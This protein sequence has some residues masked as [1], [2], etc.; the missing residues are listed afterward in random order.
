VSVAKASFD[1]RLEMLKRVTERESVDFVVSTA[2]QGGWRIQRFWNSQRSPSGWP[3][4]TLL[5]EGSDGNEM[6]CIECKTM[7]GRTRPGQP[8]CLDLIDGVVTV[9]AYLLRPSDAAFVSDRLL[10]APR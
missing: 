2:K 3:D 8:E 7:T 10:R 9:E 4:L 6:V 1:A 5:R